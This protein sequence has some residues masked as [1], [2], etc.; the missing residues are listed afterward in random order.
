MDQQPP[1][2]RATAD[3]I[4][5]T[6]PCG[7]VHRFAPPLAGRIARCPQLQGRF[8]IPTQNATV[9]FLE[10]DSPVQPT[11]KASLPQPQVEHESSEVSRHRS[12]KRVALASAGACLAL[13]LVSIVGVD[14]VSPGTLPFSPIGLLGGDTKSFSVVDLSA[15]GL[16]EGLVVSVQRSDRLAGIRD[17]GDVA[18]VY[19]VNSKDELRGVLQDLI[20]I[21]EL[22]ETRAK[23]PDE[24]LR[25]RN[26]PHLR[27]CLLMQIKTDGSLFCVGRF[28][29]PGLEM[30]FETFVSTEIPRLP[31]GKGLWSGGSEKITLPAQKREKDVGI[32]GLCFLSPSRSKQ[33]ADIELSTD[34]SCK[35]SRTSRSAPIIVSAQVWRRQNNADWTPVSTVR[36]LQLTE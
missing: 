35:F 33:N 21:K 7:E 32:H 10:A 17:T 11:I 19:V 8:K 29:V 2:M 13:I 16:L 36:D 25:E 9:V 30:Q 6:C 12:R 34:W 20:A 26:P 28:G 31:K 27:R 1:Q 3:V 5:V 22:E 14:W 4:E 24:G 18:L 23:L 15:R